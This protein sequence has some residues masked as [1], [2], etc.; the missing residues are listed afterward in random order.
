M[1]LLLFFFTIIAQKFAALSF[2]LKLIMESN[3]VIDGKIKE[4]ELV[5]KVLIATIG[6]LLLIA[7]VFETIYACTAVN[8]HR[9]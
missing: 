5:I 1:A 4:S 6:G 3:G 8:D 2:K 7:I 9:H